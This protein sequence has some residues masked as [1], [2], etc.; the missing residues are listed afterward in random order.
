MQ[1]L[2]KQKDQGLV[3][4]ALQVQKVDQGLRNKWKNF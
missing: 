3:N 2:K 1:S 4:Q